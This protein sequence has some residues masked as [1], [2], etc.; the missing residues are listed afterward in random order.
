[1]GKRKGS[2]GEGTW[3]VPGGHLEFGETIEDCA[4][5]EVYEETGLV[6]TD[7]T[8]A[9]ITND[10]FSEEE[11]HY[12]TIWVISR[13]KEGEPQI[14]EPDKLLD[15]A[16][17]DFSTIPNN[18]FLPWQNLFQSDFFIDIKALAVNS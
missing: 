11:K 6:I 3:S 18:L 1:M 16:W 10:I 15:L 17:Y 7:V 13:W 4:K 5:R 8:V 2:H 12:I 14:K 9:G